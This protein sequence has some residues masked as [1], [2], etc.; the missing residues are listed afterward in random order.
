MEMQ[1]NIKFH[2]V[3]CSSLLE[4]N[5][6]FPSTALIPCKVVKGCVNYCN[7]INAHSYCIFSKP[8]I[9]KYTS[10]PVYLN[11]MGILGSAEEAGETHGKQHNKHEQSGKN[12]SR[13]MMVNKYG[14]KN[15]FSV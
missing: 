12:R 14:E 6:L 11:D 5:L 13:W 10:V 3:C 1:G 4:N 9:C 2:F 7:G 15:K 8:C